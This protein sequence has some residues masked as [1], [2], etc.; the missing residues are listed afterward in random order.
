LEFIRRIDIFKSVFDNVKGSN[1]TIFDIGEEYYLV[2]LD[3][4]EDEVFEHSPAL[5]KKYKEKKKKDDLNRNQEWDSV[6]SSAYKTIQKL[7]SISFDIYDTKEIFNYFN[8]FINSLLKFSNFGNLYNFE[9]YLSIFDETA[10]ANFTPFSLL[11]TLDYEYFYEEDKQEQDELIKKDTNLYKMKNLK[12]SFIETFIDINNT[13]FMDILTKL[14]TDN[15]MFDPRKEYVQ[16]FK[17]FINSNQGNNLHLL[18][19]FIC[20]L[21]KMLFYYSE[22]MQDKF[23]DFINDEDFFPNMNR[24][25]NYQIFLNQV[26]YLI[27]PIYH[28]KNLPLQ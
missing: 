26:I 1:D 10:E 3:A 9:S 8:E 17:S 25:L 18:N 5:K 4:D 28:V 2:P 27:Y 16:L 23:E 12:D 20:I 14:Q 6:V 11:E 7:K 15:F 21:T 19:I 22:G 13:N 24:I